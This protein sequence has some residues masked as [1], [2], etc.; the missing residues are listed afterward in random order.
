MTKSENLL[1]R[2]KSCDIDINVSFNELVYKNEKIFVDECDK[3]LFQKF[4]WHI[5]KYGYIYTNVR[6]HRL[7]LLEKQNENT[8]VDHI[9]GNRSNNTKNNLRIVT[10]KQNSQN[11]RKSTTNKIG[12]KGV[13]EENGYFRASVHKNGNYCRIGSFVNPVEAAYAYREEEK[14]F[15]VYRSDEEFE[16]EISIFLS[17]NPIHKKEIYDF[18]TKRSHSSVKKPPKNLNIS[19]GIYKE[20]RKYVSR[21]AYGK[22][23]HYNGKYDCLLEALEVTRK[24]ELEIK[25]SDIRTQEE[26]EKEFSRLREQIKIK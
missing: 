8:V 26:Y 24:K 23:K 10:K 4:T 11:R 17:K 2:N 14:K 12:L 7:I 13:T 5:K 6:M 3:E 19:W 9:D 21:F 15:E 25:G 1:L 18:K 22:K 20:G 16:N